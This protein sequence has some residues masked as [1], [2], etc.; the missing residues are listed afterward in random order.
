MRLEIKRKGTFDEYEYF[1]KGSN[2]VW[3]DIVEELR[4]SYEAKKERLASA[5]IGMDLRELDR[6]LIEKECARRVYE[7][8]STMKNPVKDPNKTEDVK[9]VNRCKI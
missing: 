9:P 4:L 6:L 5:P 1:L 7:S 3:S 8:F 2:P